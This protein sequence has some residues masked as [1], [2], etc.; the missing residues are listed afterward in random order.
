MSN[1]LVKSPTQC[2]VYDKMLGMMSGKNGFCAYQDKQEGDLKTPLVSL[3]PVALYYRSDRVQAL[4]SFLPTY[5]I[6]Q[7]CGWCDDPS[8]KNYNQFVTLPY[9]ASAEKLYRDDAC[10]DYFLVTDYNYL[11]P[12]PHKGSAIFIHLMHSDHRPTAGC[13]AFSKADF[14]FI[15]KHLQP[16]DA[17]VMSI[18]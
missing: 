16:S 9:P 8:D 11:N 18:L 6:T 14:T 17:F 15:I 7:N 3:K 10:Y 12:I 1:I 2:L 5:E 13:L 4:D